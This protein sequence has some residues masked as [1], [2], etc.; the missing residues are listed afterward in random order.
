MIKIKFFIVFIILIGLCEFIHNT[1]SLCATGKLYV[2]TA[3]VDITPQF[4]IT[5]SGYDGRK[6]PSKGVHDP[7]FARFLVLDVDG[8]R[9]AI[10]SCDLIGYNNKDILDIAR[11]RFNIPHLLICSSHTHSGP[12]LRDSETYARSV[13]KAMV[14]GL[15]EAVKNMFPARVSAR[16]GCPPALGYMRLAK[17][18]DGYGRLLGNNTERI[19]YGPVDPYNL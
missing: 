15:D 12:N 14:K 18:E 5:M 3:K 19:P 10:I 7:L 13:D 4:S 1:H 8:Y 6:E 11:E 9:I 2:G 16:Y 17:G